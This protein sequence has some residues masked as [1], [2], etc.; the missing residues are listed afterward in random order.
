M[1][2]III[3]ILL[4]IPTAAHAENSLFFTP[5]EMTRIHKAIQR[6]Q[7]AGQA[8]HLIHMSS[9]LYFGPNH[10]VIWLRGE[11]WTPQTKNKNITIQEITNSSARLTIKHPTFAGSR[12]I[13]LHPHQSYNLLTGKVQ[14][15][16]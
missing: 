10:W 8:K 15:G 13:K 12:E 9:L 5:H 3:L 6:N 1:K 4:C 7:N 14:E 11:K 16:F 2:H